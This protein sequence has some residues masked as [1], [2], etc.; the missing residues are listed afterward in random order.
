M[1]IDVRGNY[2]LEDLVVVM[3]HLVA[4]LDAL[5]VAAAEDVSI[6]LVPRAATG[7]RLAVCDDDGLA[8]HLELEI[9]DL[10]RPCL[11]TGRLR[12]VE[13]PSPRRR[14]RAASRARY[15]QGHGV[16]RSGQ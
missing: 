4:Q 6:E 8:A 1:R 2:R 5:G 11:R 16:G 12:V 10:L 9:A 14:S 7:R 13:A 15:V 3:Q